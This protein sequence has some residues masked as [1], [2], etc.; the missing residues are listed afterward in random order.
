MYAYNFQLKK[1][2][3]EGF[4]LYYRYKKIIHNFFWRSLQIAGRQG[5]I[6]LIFMLSAKF[7]TPEEFGEL[8]YVLAIIFFLI[9]FSDFGI[10]TAT[11]KY[12]AEYKAVDKKKLKSL[13]SSSLSLIAL[14]SLVV[15]VFT[16]LF[17]KSLFKEHYFYILYFLPLFFLIPAI[18]LFDGIYRGF[19]RFKLLSSISLVTGVISV[20]FV[21][22]LV[23]NY[24]LIGAIVSQNLF[25]FILFITLFIFYKEKCFRINKTVLKEIGSYSLLIGIASLGYFLYTRIDI[26][27]LGQFGHITEIGYYEII[28][29]FFQ[30]S[31]IPFTILGQVVAPDIARLH[32]QNKFNILKNSFLKLSKLSFLAGILVAILIVIFFP[33]FLK[34]FLPKY[35][36]IEIIYIMAILLFLLPIKSIGR[37]MVQ[38]YITP[39]GYA[40]IVSISTL[41]FGLINVVLDFIFYYYFGFIGI[42]FSTVLVGYGSFFVN[43]FYFTRKIKSESRE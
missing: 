33:I 27:I 22:F 12:A 16:I 1:K 35:F 20:G 41:C 29:K 37:V 15:V 2:L 9:T 38:G 21:Y 26:I 32:A 30:L 11:S 34:T 28:N 14:L 42:F 19:K 10:S 36:L 18:S 6:F 31:L 8:N 3:N 40:K 7:L 4:R 13:L 23:K 17:G 39:A 24:R 5:I 43:F 25:Y